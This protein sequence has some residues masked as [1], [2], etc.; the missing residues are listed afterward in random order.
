MTDFVLPNSIDFVPDIVVVGTQESCSVRFEWEVSLQETL[1]PSHLLLHSA[2]L[3]LCYASTKTP[4]FNLNQSIFSQALSTW[5][6]S[7]D[8]I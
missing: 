7:F 5:L 8:A 1:G 6:C 2:N 4:T 3:G